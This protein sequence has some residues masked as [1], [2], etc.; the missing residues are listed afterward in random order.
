MTAETE[1]IAPPLA[2][3]PAPIILF[4]RHLAPRGLKYR[5]DFHCRLVGLFRLHAFQIGILDGK[6]DT[7]IRTLLASRRAPSNGSVHHI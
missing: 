3:P 1:V 7:S 5:C 2:P 4:R 6:R